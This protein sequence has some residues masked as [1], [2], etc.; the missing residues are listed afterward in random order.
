M[1]IEL[2]SDALIEALKQKYGFKL[3]KDGKV[4]I[5]LHKLDTDDFVTLFNAYAREEGED[6]DDFFLVKVDEDTVESHVDGNVT[7]I[8]LSILRGN[9]KDEIDII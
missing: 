6:D 3:D 4:D 9:I 7:R 5:D 2:S 8:P 1:K